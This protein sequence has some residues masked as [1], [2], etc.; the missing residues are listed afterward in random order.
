[1]KAQEAQQK[2]PRVM[3]SPLLSVIT[4]IFTLHL[5]MVNQVTFLMTVPLSAMS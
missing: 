5:H 3:H 1:M 4:R 2:I